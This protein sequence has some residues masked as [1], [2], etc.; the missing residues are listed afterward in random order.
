MVHS[1]D[2]DD[3]SEVHTLVVNLCDEEGG[4]S[5]VQ[6]CAIHVDSRPH[7]NDKRRHSGIDVIIMLQ[8]F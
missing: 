6:G 2:G 1:P 4:H 7:R 8:T 5:L 3:I